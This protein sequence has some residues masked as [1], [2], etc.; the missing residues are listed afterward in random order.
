MEV[1]ANGF[2][3]RSPFLVGQ[4][5]RGEGREGLNSTGVTS[6]LWGK[7]GKPTKHQRQPAH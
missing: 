7:L 6:L 1:A 4:E 3:S 5:N 2:P